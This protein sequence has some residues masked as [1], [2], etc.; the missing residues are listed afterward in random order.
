MDFIND[1]IKEAVAT[2]ILILVVT[3]IIISKLVRRFAGRPIELNIEQIYT[4]TCIC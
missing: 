3:R 4:N 2:G 1:F